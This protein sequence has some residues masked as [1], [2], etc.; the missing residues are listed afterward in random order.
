M[1]EFVA[2]NI[3]KNACARSKV[4][5]DGAQKNCKLPTIRAFVH[6]GHISK[7]NH[8]N[9]ST[10]TILPACTYLRL[11]NLYVSSFLE[12]EPCTSMKPTER[13]YSQ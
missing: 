3:P 9:K 2:I 4:F 8:P 6:G 12:I 11:R 13:L 1:N 10:D 5:L 7:S